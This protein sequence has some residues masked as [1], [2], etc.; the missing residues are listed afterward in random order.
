MADAR[1]GA[2]LLVAFLAG[3]GDQDLRKDVL[4]Y[5]STPFLKEDERRDLVGRLRYGP[6]ALLQRQLLPLIKDDQTRPLAMELA[7]RLR[8]PG[9]A[10]AARKYLDTW[11]E[12][13]VLKLLIEVQ[14]RTS[15]NILFD[16]WCRSPE[17][18]AAFHF[19]QRA[20]T[21]VEIGDLETLSKFEALCAK[22]GTSASQKRAAEAILR[23]QMARPNADRDAL[24]AAWKPFKA[25][26]LRDAQAFPAGGG[27]DLLAVEGWS[28]EN[29]RR[30]GG[31][32]RLLPEGRM[33]L[34]CLPP[35]LQ[36]GD[37]VLRLKVLADV[38]DG[39]AVALREWKLAVEEGEWRVRS[40]LGTFVAP[41]RAGEWQEIA[42]SVFDLSCKGGVREKRKILVSVDR[43][44]LGER[45]SLDGVVEGLVI[46][47][48]KGALVVA[49]LEAIPR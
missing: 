19:V 7:T 2:V 27:I 21:E 45:G 33:S 31:N 28:R 4:S 43:K 37:F 12:A 18:S 41:L 23:F 35:V 9:L 48:G 38:G 42:F 29:G 39:A 17:G 25:A 22:P 15:M 47:A 46:Q 10:E 11:E 34:A 40:S 8:V 3:A 36:S 26:F 20:F 30:V 16:R 13:S 6:P 49:G 1:I 32:Y 14:D 24:R 44:P 5:V